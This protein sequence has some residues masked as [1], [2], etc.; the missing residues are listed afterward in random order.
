MTSHVSLILHKPVVLQIMLPILIFK[1]VS[2]TPST[3]FPNKT[4]S[5]LGSKA[6]DEN[7]KTDSFSVG[8]T[9]KLLVHW[10]TYKI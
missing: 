10:K 5:P 6:N 8:R 9:V 4:A 2:D 3:I 1:T 7:I